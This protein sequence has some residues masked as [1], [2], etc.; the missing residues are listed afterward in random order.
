MAKNARGRT[1]ESTENASC[2]AS[3][4][5][6]APAVHDAAIAAPRD[7][8]GFSPTHRMSRRA[9][10]RSTRVSSRRQNARQRPRGDSESPSSENAEAVV[11][12]RRAT[13]RPGDGVERST[14]WSCRSW[15]LTGEP[16]SREETTR[17]VRAPRVATAARDTGR[18]SCA[19]EPRGTAE[20]DATEAIAA[21]AR[22]DELWQSRSR[23]QTPWPC[24][25]YL[26]IF[27]N[28]CA[29]GTRFRPAH[30]DLVAP[31]PSPW[32]GWS[33]RLPRGSCRPPR[34]CR[35]A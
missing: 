7:T 30:S 11:L 20:R 4:E 17:R 18:R 12:G 14:G 6:T 31:R 19:A 9:E 25:R 33:M 26:R 22:C 29:M 24:G 15:W 34:A 28:R 5:A 21:I 10:G 1:T 16:P 35:T 8:S 13:R 27:E 3:A 32:R 23:K 2:S